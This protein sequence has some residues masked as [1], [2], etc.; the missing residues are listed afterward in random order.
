MFNSY[1]KTPKKKSVVL[2]KSW[3]N[4]AEKYPLVFSTGIIADPKEWNFQ[5][6]KFKQGRKFKLGVTKNG[7]LD[8][9][10]SE[11][12]KYIL[13]R[14]VLELRTPGHD[15]LKNH[16]TSLKNRIH[17]IVTN[18]LGKK[19]DILSFLK[20]HITNLQSNA[21]RSKNYVLGFITLERNLQ[22]YFYKH[23]QMGHGFDFIKAAN[24][25]H[26]QNWNFKDNNHSQNTVAGYWKRF[27]TVLN[28]A[29]EKG[30]IIHPDPKK[31]AWRHR[32]LSI[33][34]Q[35]ADEIYLIPKELMKL[36]DL[37]LSGSFEK[38]RDIFLL[39]AFT[40]YR[41]SDVEGLSHSNIVPIGN[42]QLMKIH[43]KKTDTKIYSPTGWY[44]K[45]FLEKYKSGF[46][47]IKNQQVYGR[48]LKD[49]GEKA[50]LNSLVKLRKNFGGK[51]K[52]VEKEKYKW[53][54]PYTSRYSFASNLNDA[55][56]QLTHIRDLMGHNNI[57][58]TERY[59]KSQ[60]AMAAVKNINNPYF[61]EKPKFN[62][63]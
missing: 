40:G 59:I 15:E 44:L 1:L 45:E 58:Q 23:P 25:K 38:H 8:K 6:K 27:K 16:L 54:M 32:S 13:E 12:E 18:D 34:F 61:A 28:A 5:T 10:K 62:I 47:T 20:E 9:Y 39:D 49:I 51:N 14:Q 55:G 50:G 35:A 21:Q 22:L 60:K 57:K 42:L 7:F 24:L 26:W 52:T 30:Y 37:S 17:G 11:A 63:G 3:Y 29:D 36:Y 4:K 2:L 56:V 46:P 41:P 43:A 53:I 19:I 33:N 48:N 31:V